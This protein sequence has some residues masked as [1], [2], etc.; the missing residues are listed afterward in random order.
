MTQKEVELKIGKPLDRVD[1]RL[2]VTG[3]ARYAAEWKL[4]NLAYGVAIQSTIPTGRVTT[5]SVDRARQ[6]SGVIDVFS[7]K[8]KPGTVSDEEDAREDAERL[9]LFQ[10][11]E[12]HYAGQIIALVVADNLTAARHAAKLVNIEYERESFQTDL[13]ANLKHAKKPEDAEDH[14]RGDF[15]KAFLSAPVKVSQTYTTPMETHNPLEPFGVTAAWDGDELTLYDSTQGV[16][17][18]K[19]TVAKI[20]KLAKEEVRVLSPFVGGGFGSKLT[21]WAH[22]PLAAMAARHLKR[23]V[24]LVLARNQMYGPVGCRPATVQTVSL[25]AENDGR[26]IAI[27]HE[28]ISE[29]S[30]FKDYIETVADGAFSIYPS[31]H[32]LA[33][34]RIVPLD[35]GEATWMRAP[36][37]A[38]GSYALECAMDELAHELKMDPVEFRLKNW[39]NK[40]YASDLPWSSNSL[41]ECYRVAAEKFGWQNRNMQPGSKR[42]GSRLVGHGMATAF[43][44]VWRNP[45]SAKAI[46]HNDGTVVVQSAT[47]DIGTGTYTA[48]TLVAAEKLDLPAASIKVELGDSNLPYA[49]VSGGSTT[50]GSVGTAVAAVCESLLSNLI[51]LAINDSK[52]PLHKKHADDVVA[53][54]GALCLKTD[55]SVRETFEAIVR[56]TSTGQI[57]ASV[58]SKPGDEEEKFA[59]STFGAH[60]VEVSVDADLGKVRVERWVGAFDAGRIVNPKTARSQILG[61]VTFGIGMALLEHTLIDHNIGRIVNADIAE[62]HI[63]SHA[64]VHDIDVIFLEP[65]DPHVNKLGIKGIGELGITGAAAA[66]ANAVFNATGKRVRELPITLDKLL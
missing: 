24:K 52:S 43:H 8:N 5:I 25:A 45:A 58:D 20:L 46:M 6:V 42:D 44:S 62:Y 27:K 18:T 65:V 41:R 7:Y 38:T 21:V 30:K 35:I 22:V 50:M 54:R 14:K 31:E 19:Q 47:H 9:F 66:V 33:T 4:E 11:N 55:E 28:G 13:S 29:T 63:P 57:E 16:Y 32:A 48:L 64:D 1:G 60:F 26:L 40:D 17:S 2:K 15:K 34:H 23:P 10:D 61:G 56:R 37:H 36:G 49:P 59:M 39:A 53:R 51:S 3:A 12:I